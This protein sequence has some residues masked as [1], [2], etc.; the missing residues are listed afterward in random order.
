[1]ILASTISRGKNLR[2][3]ISKMIIQFEAKL[4]GVPWAI[5]NLPFT[6]LPTMVVGVD[7]SGNLTSKKTCV[8]S[9]VSTVDNKFSKYHSQSQ[10][11]NNR[12][13]FNQKL[14]EMIAKS[15]EAFGNANKKMFPKNIICYREGV[16]EGMRKKTKE[17]EVKQILDQ[18]KSL[19]EKHKL[20][21]QKDLNLVYL[22]VSKSN[23]AKFFSKRGHRGDIGCPIQGSYIFN[24]ICKD[25]N[26]FFLISQRPGKGLSAPSNYYILHNDLT[27][28][29][30]KTAERVRHEL[31][32]LS[33]KLCYLYYNTVGSIKVPAPIHYANRMASFISEKSTPQTKIIPHQHLANIKSLYFI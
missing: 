5:N 16:S 12:E 2:S 13:E 22:L 28:K 27:E 20:D 33:F 29:K 6:N 21:E 30:L 26:E 23:G 4:G 25:E 1:M 11:V 7:I 24:G 18:I 19:R 14:G 31:A 17:T 15:I 10:F 8:M 32:S 9:V 3:I